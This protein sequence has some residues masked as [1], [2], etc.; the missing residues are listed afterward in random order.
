YFVP[1]AICDG[2]GAMVVE[3]FR[4]MNKVAVVVDLMV[5]VDLVVEVSFVE[6]IDGN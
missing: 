3:A 2:D 4:A 6:A 5:M 1:V